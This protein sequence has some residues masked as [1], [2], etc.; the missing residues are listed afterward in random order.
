MIQLTGAAA[1]LA[2][3]RSRWQGGGPRPAAV[4]LLALT[5]SEIAG[6]KDASWTYVLLTHATVLPVA[7]QHSCEPSHVAQPHAMR[8]EMVLPTKRT[9][10]ERS[11]RQP[12]HCSCQA[13]LEPSCHLHAWPSCAVCC[14]QS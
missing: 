3:G 9:H 1:S 10:K 5:G 12:L 7:G 8:Y 11:R 6:L 13:P 4:F 14:V 2:G